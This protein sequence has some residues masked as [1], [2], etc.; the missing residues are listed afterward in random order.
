MR[1]LAIVVVLLISACID[2]RTP[3]DAQDREPRADEL[4]MQLTFSTHDERTPGWSADGHFIDYIGERYEGGTERGR[5]LRVP[6]DGSGPSRPLFRSL[7]AYP[8][9]ML[10]REAPGGGRVAFIEVHDLRPGACR[11][12]SAQLQC[13][14]AAFQPASELLVELR[15]HVRAP[16]SLEPVQHDPLR[17]LHLG[18]YRYDEEDRVQLGMGTEV[19]TLLPYH[20]LFNREQ[21][22]S[23]RPDWSPDGERLVYSDGVS[24]HIWDLASDAVETIPGTTHGVSPAWSP[25]G[26][27]IVYTRL[28][29]GAETF[30]SC[31]GRQAGELVCALEQTVVEVADRVLVRVRPDGSDE[32]VLGQGEDPA[33]GPDGSLYYRHDN[34]LWRFGPEPFALPGTAGG[35]E[36]AVSPDGRR[37]V[38]AWRNAAGRYDLWVLRLDLL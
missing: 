30:A 6:A 4:L 15:L 13:T 14:G 21:T 27:W 22:W 34:R 12:L 29:P 28:V 17:V 38:F 19:I 25:D 26:A 9:L 3:F 7:P 31:L 32:Q 8:W 5:V 37:L 33:W 20:L 23:F 11:G 1:A 10:P 35:R 18:A 36:P 24:L 2:A 16:E